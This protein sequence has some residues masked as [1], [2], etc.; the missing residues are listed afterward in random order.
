MHNNYMHTDQKKGLQA[1]QYVA[2]RWNNTVLFVMERQIA[3]DSI[4][5]NVCYSMSCFHTISYSQHELYS[6]NN[7]V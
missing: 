4:F 6:T 7:F 1:K 5:G 2:T 3:T